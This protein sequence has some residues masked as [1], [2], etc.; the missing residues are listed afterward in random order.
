MLVQL[1]ETQTT[2]DQRFVVVLVLIQHLL[3]ILQGFL[4]GSVVAMELSEIK[5]VLTYKKNKKQNFGTKL[6]IY[7]N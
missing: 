2:E 3:D 6:F 5:N 1:S 7:A 4:H